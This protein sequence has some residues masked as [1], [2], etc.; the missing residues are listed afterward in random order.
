MKRKFLWATFVPAAVAL[1]LILNVAAAVKDAPFTAEYVLTIDEV[2][3]NHIVASGPGSGTVVG[4]SSLVA[5]VQ[6]H[7]EK[8]VGSGTITAANGDLIYTVSTQTEEPGKPGVGPYTIVGGTGRFANV[9]GTGTT[10]ATDNPDGTVTAT[11]DGTI[12][13]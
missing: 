2:Y 10:I 6:R 5:H 4:K 1:A 9:S 7:G 8:F 3:G 11:Y 13:F 12:S